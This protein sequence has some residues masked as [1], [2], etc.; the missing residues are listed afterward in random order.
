MTIDTA[1]S[2]PAPPTPSGPPA[3]KRRRSPVRWIIGAVVVAVLLLV[4]GPF[5]YIHLF[6]SDAPAPLTLSS[7]PTSAASAGA[8]P[9]TTAASSG[10]ASA[11][12]ATSTG[13]LNGTW[14][15][16]SGSQAG[17][18]VSEVL[19]GQSTEALGRTTAVTGNATIANNQLTAATFSV[20]LTKVTSDKSQRDSLFQDR[21]MNTSTY[22]TATFKLTKPIDL[23]T[24][25]ADGTTANYTA[26]GDLT[27]HGVTKSVDIPLQAKRDGN[28]ISVSGS[29]GVTFADFAISNPS[30]GPAQVG[31]NGTLELLVNLSQS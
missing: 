23:S 15:V 28:T 1:S 25:P 14:T 16:A 7:T 10:A 24:V 9:S 27:M 30:A 5:L 22:P 8:S 2:T 20:D 6:S 31:D 12:A 19:L 11:G 3:T 13:S 4:G 29:Y 21:I 17:Y 26:T 18:R